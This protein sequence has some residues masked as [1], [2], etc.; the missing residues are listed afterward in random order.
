MS[1]LVAPSLLGS[2][3][4]MK[5][6]ETEPDGMPFNKEQNTENDYYDE[7]NT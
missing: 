6:L 3:P 4:I 7:K 1:F 2:C 5:P